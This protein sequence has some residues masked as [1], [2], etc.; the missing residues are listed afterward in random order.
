MKT[1]THGIVHGKTIELPAQAEPTGSR[2]M[3]FLLDTDT[4][5]AHLSGGGEK[6]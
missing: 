2:S 5:S 6:P 4:C 3:S 1:I